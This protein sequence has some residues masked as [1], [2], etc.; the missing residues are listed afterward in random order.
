MNQESSMK[1]TPVVHLAVWGADHAL[2][3]F[4]SPRACAAK[5]KHNKNIINVNNVNFYAE[6]LCEKKV[7]KFTFAQEGEFLHIS[8]QHLLIE[9]NA[10]EI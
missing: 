2:P 5:K 7:W 6:N 9:K 3:Y 1:I 4:S 10:F 8:L